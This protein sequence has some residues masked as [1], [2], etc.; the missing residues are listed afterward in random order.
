MRAYKTTPTTGYVDWIVNDQPDSTGVYS[1]YDPS[2]LI[3]VTV[4]RIVQSK[5]DNF[6]K[7][8]NSDDGYFFH[9]NSY[10]WL[11]PPGDGYPTTLAEPPQITGL[12]AVRGYTLGPT[13]RDHACMFWDETLS[14]WKFAYNTSGDG[15]TVG[16]S[17]P[18][19]TGL[20]SIDGYLAVGTDPA[21]S[22]IIRI[23]NIGTT[24]PI[25]IDS[26]EEVETHL[27]LVT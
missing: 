6:L 24:T 23:P 12:A 18:V 25:G 7:P 27:I 20:L 5:I 3:N 4:N 8:L 21:L 2:E 19:F 9:L 13:P 17:L 16:A 14:G 10:D 22:G 26:V 15:Y 1:G 11:H